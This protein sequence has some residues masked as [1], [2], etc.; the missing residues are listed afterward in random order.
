[1]HHP[2][3]SSGEKHGSTGGGV[4]ELW[5]ALY[6]ADTD[7]ILSA[8]EHNYERFSPQDPEGR[9][10]LERGIRQ[11]VVGIGGAAEN[12]PIGEPMENSEVYNDETDGVLRLNF[13]IK[14]YRAPP[15]QS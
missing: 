13:E 12:Y 15:T 5:E 9:A 10:D 11:F 8:Y 7:V 2:R 4:E 1:M 6:E 14:G 3:F